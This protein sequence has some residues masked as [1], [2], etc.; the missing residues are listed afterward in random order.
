[1]KHLLAAV[2]AALLLCA[3]DASF[4]QTYT[5]VIT[6]VVKDQQ[7]GVLP[8]VTITLNGKTGTKSEV[9]DAAGSY[10]FPG[11]DPGT[12]VVTA[13]LSNFQTARQEGIVVTVGS[14]LNAD[15]I[16]K[17]GGVSE[18]VNVIGE[19]PVVDVKSSATETNISQDLLTT[20]PITRT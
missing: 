7:G 14:T 11:L 16:L 13:T 2:S 9:T 1:M 19:S 20:A 8:G 15:L 18:A 4:A 17:V 3:A 12:Y 5:G 6:G 10:R